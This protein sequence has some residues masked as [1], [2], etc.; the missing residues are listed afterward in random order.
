MKGRRKKGIAAVIM[1]ALMLVGLVPSDFT[2]VQAKAATWDVEVNAGDL[3]AETLTA[4]KTV[5]EFFTIPSGVQIDANKKYVNLD[6]TSTA[7]SN[8]IK[9]KANVKLKFTVPEG[10]KATIELYALCGSSGAPAA[11]GNVYVYN[12][13]DDTTVGEVGRP[14]KSE[15]VDSNSVKTGILPITYADIPAGTYYLTD[16]DYQT[17]I[18]YLRAKLDTVAQDKDITVNVGDLTAET[19]TADKTVGE[20]F[21]IPSGVQID[22][23]K[24]YVNL[25]GTST[26]ISNR[27]KLKANVKLKFTVPEGQ[28]ATIELYALCGSSGAPAA[29]GNVYVYNATDDTTVGEVGRP[30]KSEPVDSNSV[31]T[32]I[33]PITYADIPAG[34][35]YLTDASYQTNIYYLRAYLRSA[36][37]PSGTAPVVSGASAALKAGTDNVAHITWSIDTA[38]S[39]DGKLAVDVYK[40]GTKLVTKTMEDAAATEY[41][42]EMT[43]SGSYTF[44]VYG[45]LG[46]NTT[47]EAETSTPVVYTKTLGKPSVTAKEGDSKITLSWGEVAE[48]TSYK[49]TI[50]DEAGTAVVNAEETVEK[51]FTKEGLTN[52]TKYTCTVTAVRSSDSATAV[53]DEVVCMPYQAPD[54][55]SAIPGMNVINQSEDNQISISRTGGS[56]LVSQP[57]TGGGIASSGITNTSF[58]LTPSTVTGDFTMSADITVEATGSGT[59]PGIYFGMF[60]GTESN[61]KLATVAFR[62]DK[63][64][65]AYR[66]KNEAENA[67]NNGGSNKGAAK[68]ATKYTYTIIR[69]GTESISIK[70]TDEDK[71]TVAENTW[72]IKSGKD[73]VD[74][75]EDLKGPVRL[76]FAVY[77]AS[78][79]VENLKIVQGDNT[80]YD[81]SK[82]TGSFSSFI[83]NWDKVDAPVISVEGSKDKM[84]VTSDCVIGPTGAGSVKVEMKDSTGK[85]VATQSK[86]SM[87]KQQ[88][89]EFAPEFSGDYT[90][91]ATASRPSEDKT[92][93]S[94]TVGINGFVSTLHAP[95][96]ITATSQGAGEIKVEWSAYKEAT[97]GYRVSY[98]VA[99]A[100]GDYTVVG[101]TTDTFKTVSGLT[102]GTKYEFKVEALRGTEA[103]GATVTSTASADAKFKWEFAAFGSST[104]KAN[105]G[106]VG[107]A[108][109]GSVQVFSEGGKGKIVPNSTDG[110]A[111]YYTKLPVTTNFTLKAKV[112]A[113]KWT[114]SN[115]QEGFGVMAADRVGVNGDSSTFWNNMYQAIATKVEYY[116]DE[117]TGEVSD[118]GKKISMKLGLGVIERVGVTQENL[119]KLEAGDTAT[120]NNEFRTETQTLET[121]C[122]GLNAGTYNVIGN[123]TNQAVTDGI[124][125]L[126]EFYLTIQKNNTGYFV[127]YSD[128]QGNPV[129]TI[130]HYDTEALSQVDKDSVYVGFFASRNARATFSDITLTLI[131]PAN[132]A[133]A[134]EKPIKYVTPSYTVTSP[135]ATGNSSYDFTFVSTADGRLTIDG[136]AGV[137]DVWVNANE[138]FVKNKTLRY[139]EN[140]FSITFTPDPNFVPLKGD[141]LTSYEPYNFGHVVTY[142]TIGSAGESIWVSPTGTSQGSGHVTNPVDIYTAVKYVQPGQQIILKGGHYDLWDTVKTARGNNGYAD[143]YIYMIAD[144]DSEERPVLDFHNYCP[145]MVLAG[146]YWYFKGFDVTKSANAQKGIQVSGSNN[147]LDQVNAYHNGNTG[148]QISRLL[149][150]DLWD[151]WPAN[152]LILNCTSYGNADKGYEDADGFAA[153]LTVADGNVFDGCIAYNNADDGWDL[154]AK[155]ETGSIGSVTI[156]NSIAYG[157]GYLEDGT[158]AGN[159]NGFKMGGDSLSGYHKLINSIAYNNKAKGIDSNSC[160][161]IQVESSTSFNNESYNVAFY[162]NNAANT[163]YS[164]NGILSYRKG[165]SVEEQFKPKGTQDNNKI[166]GNTNYYWDKATNQ[167]ANKAGAAVDD[168]WFVSL[169]TSVAP[170]RNADGTI[171]MH[172]LLTPTDKVPEGVGARIEGTKSTE[173]IVKPSVE[174]DADEDKNDEEE[175][176][177]T[178]PDVTSGLNIIGQ[179]IGVQADKGT[180]IKNAAGQVVTAGDIYIKALPVKATESQAEAI[181]EVI[182]T[183]ELKVADNA[184]IDYFEVSLV[185][186]AGNPLTFDGKIVITFAYPNGTNAASHSFSVLHLLK[187]GEL[188]IMEPT[189]TDSGVSVAVSELSPFAVV[190]AEKAADGNAGQTL[191]SA[192]TG[193]R[194]P[195][196]PIVILLIVS[197]GIIVAG[198]I[199]SKK[200]RA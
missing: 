94:N 50:K 157:N 159:G 183:K 83:D 144:P 151:N 166:Y 143:K 90:F 189:L 99:D 75:S 66:T 168:T 9:L 135:T 2:L 109:D 158:N 33:L 191:V 40:D 102:V 117:A 129:R 92:Y 1:A 128:A 111:F 95:E 84:V 15:P 119:S 76:G 72:G 108:N 71:N 85:V 192:E 116:V 26:A 176:V 114:L 3:T 173:I 200:K 110:L 126:T 127:T 146:D 174:P 93:T 101:T 12:A 150:T 177:I 175:T 44:K 51:T 59:G 149:G 34:T 197:A 97:S 133:P 132:D 86:S 124:Q 82:L 194:T 103:Q 35:Y 137:E 122:A 89:F 41:D 24:K 78:A 178:S 88:T 52:L 161:D 188:D 46:T 8:R 28:K 39:G 58:V 113:D 130:K 81:A 20:F 141:K 136:I 68:L 11:G 74:F 30:L 47:T 153:K 36:S 14:L 48:A 147:V 163:D 67:Y 118:A 4:D 156:K 19:L 152:N 53:S 112:T 42:Y 121:S 165:T 125:G 138:P 106:F 120:V 115:A 105:N 104:D 91:V 139:G 140:Y 23:N 54:T 43:A 98:K 56:I 18:Y 16:T 17:N 32:G 160:P 186:I 62:G 45:K 10:Q 7:I 77:N 171:N 55:S 167:S 184:G 100:A 182:K 198:I 169:D 13:T 70:V 64:F 162:T 87:G 196:I 193:D 180:V 31:K 187:S 148:I 25:D 181:L 154:F 61:S 80:V 49:V 79:K 6:G 199:I 145:G 123:S 5:G 57:A 21:T 134:E 179:N 172:G 69:T 96:N 73:F 63:N 155:V 195:I 190:Y 37:G 38:A 60:T 107:D 65:N 185:D 27:I 29:G 164:A 131:D 170:T 22:A 142:K